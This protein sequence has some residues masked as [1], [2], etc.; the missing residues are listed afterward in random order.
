MRLLDVHNMNTYYDDFHILKDVTFSVE[1]LQIVCVLGANSAGKSTLVNSIS[2]IVSPANGRITF[3][4]EPVINL[5][6]HEVADKGIIQVPEARRIF[7]L[8]TVHEN[9]LA[10]SY[11]PRARKKRKQT[12]DYVYDL[13]PVLKERRKQVAG[14]L[15]GGEQRMLAIGRGLMSVPTLLMLDEPSIGLAPIM[16]EVIYRTIAEIHKQGLSILLVEQNVQKALGLSDYAYIMESGRIS[17]H[18]P[19]SELINNSYV[20]EAYMGL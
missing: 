10:G 17:M 4:S 5:A 14:T 7:P 8:M 20:K 2:G 3:K 18:G 19:G 11:P 1:A 6:P 13:F 16:V 12:F 9:L 15:S